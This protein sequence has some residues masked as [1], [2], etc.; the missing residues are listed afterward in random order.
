VLIAQRWILARLRHETFFSL[1]ALNERIAELL[2]ELND[3]RMRVYGASRRELFERLDHPALRTSAS[4]AC[5]AR[6][7]SRSAAPASRASTTRHD[8]SSRTR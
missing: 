5:S 4:R 8:A 3:R 2:E 7:S 6:R 1:D